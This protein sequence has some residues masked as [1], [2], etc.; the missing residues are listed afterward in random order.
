MY[1]FPH[2]AGMGNDDGMLLAARRGE[3][4]QL[5]LLVLQGANVHARDG[6]TL[7]ARP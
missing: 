7:D 5:Q 2:A 6:V 4:Q 3:L 1:I